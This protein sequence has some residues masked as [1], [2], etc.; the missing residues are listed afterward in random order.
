[1]RPIHLVAPTLAFPLC[2]ALTACGDDDAASSGS[3]D[4]EQATDGATT[5]T[6]GGTDSGTTGV[7][8]EPYP[9]RGL[10]VTRVELNQGVAIPIGLDGG[11]VGGEGRNA[12]VV[13]RRDSLFRIY[14]DVA[15][16]W[17][18]REIEAR[19]TLVQADGTEKVI[20]ELFTISED[21][22]DAD[23]TS[24]PYFGVEAEDML[25]GVKYKVS[26]WE[27]QWGYENE[28]APEPAPILP[29]NGATAFVGVEDSYQNMRVVLV[30][31][32]YSYG[33][34]D[35]VVDGEA[36]HGAFHSA[37]LQQNPVENLEL[38]VHAPYEVTYDM[39]S[40]NGL[41]TL[42]NEM[43]QLRAAEG[44]TPEVYYYGIF[45]NCGKCIGAGGG[46]SG[47]C[48][49]GLAAN[50]TGGQKSDA[51][52]RAA[53][54]Q[55]NNGADQTFVHEVG[56]TQGRRHIECPSAG[57][58]AAGTDPS[59]PYENGSIHVWG[60]G[61]RD[62]SLRHPTA[63]ADYMSYCSKAWVSDWQWNATY[64]R[65]KALSEWE[66]EGGV[67]PE[68]GG[69]GLLIGAIEA[70]G[71]ED[72]WTVP[73]AL[74]ADSERSAIEAVRFSVG[75]E[76]IVEAAQIS[77]RPHGETVVVVAPLP[78]GIDLEAAELR[79]DDGDEVRAITLDPAKILHASDRLSAE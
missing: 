6:T 72:W 46:V 41:S 44:A 51:W 22:R 25:P 67:A 38:E 47:G 58:Q 73:G 7:P 20:S 2:L 16:D 1:M 15:D 9:A 33:G 52:A 68:Q 12:Y 78:A 79:F 54:G 60:F 64:K 27:T 29:V 11:E 65:I 48:T 36:I 21:T 32:D 42:V 18:E 30:P 39:G 40:Y 35:T 43:S 4:T 34:C 26:L 37:L 19:L 59:Y 74:E 50:I 69:P 8:V 45:D 24:G 5:G 77:V 57:T 23:I 13:P 63:N 70:D 28:P 62:Y 66:G 53:A 14:V 76:E 17:V 75:G 71:T 49:V 61:I 56:H 55:L 3:S 31:V 10:T